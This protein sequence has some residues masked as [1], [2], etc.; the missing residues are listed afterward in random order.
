MTDRRAVAML[1][2][3]LLAGPAC[4]GGDEASG[5]RPLTEEQAELLAGAL[6]TN[7]NG[8][9]ARITLVAGL[10]AGGGEIRLDGEVDWGAHTGHAPVTFLG[11]VRPG[12][13]DD[14][15]P[16]GPVGRFP[17]RLRGNAAQAS[18]TRRALR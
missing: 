7:R 4:G 16:D 5:P 14:P 17:P 11:G 8:P 2:V 6:V 13:R 10:G 9:P 12:E 15:R 3:A 1:V 18:G